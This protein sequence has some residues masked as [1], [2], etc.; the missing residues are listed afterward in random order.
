MN[1]NDDRIICEYGSN[2]IVY[3]KYHKM[4][5]S[6]SRG[7]LVIVR[8][9]EPPRYFP[10]K[11]AAR[12]GCSIFIPSNKNTRMRIDKF[13]HKDFEYS[14][15]DELLGIIDVLEKRRNKFNSNAV[16]R[17]RWMFLYTKMEFNP[18]LPD[19]A[20]VYIKK[21]AINFVS[22]IKEKQMGVIKPGSVVCFDID[23]NKQ[24]PFVWIKDIEEEVPIYTAESL[25]LE[26]LSKY[27]QHL[28]LFDDMMT[29]YNTEA[30]MKSH[31]HLWA[32]YAKLRK[33]DW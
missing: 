18:K 32:L 12:L 3:I 25:M 27:M 31:V 19:A 16:D 28:K 4:L 17:K 9:G 11:E 13:N 33:R 22:I 2:A 21:K 24:L 20:A 14:K 10:T 23:I 15:F 26:L 5:E 29:V 6:F 7:D 1:N 8:I 30:K